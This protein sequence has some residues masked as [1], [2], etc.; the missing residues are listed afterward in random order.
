MNS[1]TIRE[2]AYARSVEV[3]YLQEIAELEAELAAT[4]LGKRLAHCR[5]LLEVACADKADAKARVHAVALASYEATGNK[6]PHP[7]VKV[8][9]YTI[10]DY[11]LADALE[12]ARQHLPKALKLDKRTFERAAKAIEPD[13]VTIGQE[14][15]TRIASDLSSYLDTPTPSTS[16]DSD[17]A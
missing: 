3:E 2:L 15:R 16:G 8:I 10:L 13:F 14:P 6:Q 9:L 1:T 17:T 4:S 5:E 12:Y 11:D 7:A